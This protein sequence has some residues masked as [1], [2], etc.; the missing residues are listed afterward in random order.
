MAEKPVIDEQRCEGC[1]LCVTVCHLNGLVI[2]GKVVT[3]VETVECDWCTECE[4]VC[5]VGAIGCPFEIVIQRS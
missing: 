5:P 4:L 1:G 2:V 3:V